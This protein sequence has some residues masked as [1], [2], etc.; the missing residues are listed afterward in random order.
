ML[1]SPWTDEHGQIVHHFLS[2]LDI[3]RRHEA[4]AALQRLNAELEQRVDERTRELTAANVCV[5]LVLPTG[6]ND[7][8]VPDP[9][10]AAGEASS[11]R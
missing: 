7:C 9:P 11:R 2:F 10:G 6:G 8:G 1:V 3:T 5:R 4:E